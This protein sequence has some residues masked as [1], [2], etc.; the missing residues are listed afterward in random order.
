MILR[1]SSGEMSAHAAKNKVTFECG[2]SK[3]PCGLYPHPEVE[4]VIYTVC[5]S[6]V[7]DRRLVGGVLMTGMLCA[8][9]RYK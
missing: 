6:V 3:A 4:T 2:R 7:W 1:Q 8:T 5:L 9:L